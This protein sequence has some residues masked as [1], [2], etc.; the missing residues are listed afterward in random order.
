VNTFLSK[1]HNRVL[2]AVF[3][4]VLAIAAG[5]AI[6]ILPGEITTI[7]IVS[8]CGLAIL[9]AIDNVWVKKRLDILSPAPV[10]LAAYWI[11]YSVGSASALLQ[12]WGLYLLGSIMFLVGTLLAKRLWKHPSWSLWDKA[13]RS[14][15]LEVADS[16]RLWFAILI[17]LGI[18]SMGAILTAQWGGVGS[19]LLLDVARLRAKVSAPVYMPYLFALLEVAGVIVIVDL[20]AHPNTKR[21]RWYTLRSL[22]VTAFICG[23]LVVYLGA[24]AFLVPI[25]IGALLGFHYFYR[26]LGFRDF[27]LVFATAILVMSLWYSARRYGPM[28]LEGDYALDMQAGYAPLGI[29]SSNAVDRLAR[30]VDLFPNT[31]PFWLGRVFFS[32]LITLLPGHQW[33]VDDWITVY[34][35][36]RELTSI[37]GSPPTI[38]GG[39]YMDGGAFAVAMGMLIV[40]LVIQAMYL[41]FRRKPTPLRL[42]YYSYL[43][44]FVCVS[45]YGFVCLSTILLWKYAVLFV[46]WRFACTKKVASG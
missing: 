41:A 3:C 38:L 31:H 10:F 36:H 28:I 15:I 17:L 46:V 12:L 44:S 35:H 8:L 37:G 26:R 4:L 16:G 21:N 24:R 14:K 29:Q 9:W 11:Y 18:G 22:L 20:F 13:S 40:G 32:Q 27:L 7:T 30:L 23:C 6:A 43:L 2:T 33:L 5:V 1:A 19:N 25:G 42:M 45:V 34:I 39:F